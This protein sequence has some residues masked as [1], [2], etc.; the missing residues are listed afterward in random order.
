M[1]PAPDQLPSF[2]RVMSSVKAVSSTILMGILAAYFSRGYQV[3][4][5]YA[6]AR[7]SQEALAAHAVV[8]YLPMCVAFLSIGVGFTLVVLL[9]KQEGPHAGPLVRGAIA[10]CLALT[11]GLV[12]AVVLSRGWILGALDVAEQ[13][14]AGRYLTLQS[15]AS[16]LIPW[17]VL[18]KYVAVARRQLGGP[19]FA[20]GV[21][22]G[23]NILGNWLA[24]RL[25]SSPSDMLAGVATAT[26]VSQVW[27]AGFYLRRNFALLFGAIATRTKEPFFSFEKWPK[28]AASNVALLSVQFFTPFLYTFF[29]TRTGAKAEIAA[30]NVGYQLFSLLAVPLFSVNAIGSGLVSRHVS[31]GRSAVGQQL[32]TIAALG[33]LF[34]FVPASLVAALSSSLTTRAFLLPSEVSPLPLAFV[35]TL[36]PFILSLPASCLLHALEKPQAMIVFE[37]GAYYLIGMPLFFHFLG[38]STI[39]PAA[40]GGILFPTVVYSLLC[41]ALAWR[42]LRRL[43]GSESTC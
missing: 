27:L 6:V 42:A 1:T 21:G 11:F 7:I 23:I 18:L 35:L 38:S 16:L 40:L 2:S 17:N 4:D 34:G 24:L 22:L 37:I 20:D 5:Q 36:F 3:A 31:S 43:P 41:I 9:N 39:L 10:T 32:I 29:L 28:L 33:F 8:N 12:C 30:Y 26:I 19:A 25:L 15:I 14:G 13:E